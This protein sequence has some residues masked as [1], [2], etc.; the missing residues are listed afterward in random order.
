MVAVAEKLVCRYCHKE[1]KRASSLEVH[2]C[3]PKRRHN[4]QNEPGVRFG[5]QSYLR[6]YESTQGSA[7]KKTFTDFAGSPYYR[8]FT[9]FGRYCVDSRVLNPLRFTDYLLKQ[10]KKL[11]YWTS[12]ALYTEYLHDYLRVESVEDALT[13]AIEYGIA[14]EEET[15]HPAND[16]IR[17]GNANKILHAITTGRLSPW[18]FY[19][20]RSGQEFLSRL[21][22]SQV[23]HIWSYIDSEFWQKK[24]RDYP[25]DAEYAR[26]ILEKAG[27]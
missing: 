24:F 5:F 25:A 8:A 14:W 16:C 19:Q 20:S 11:D 21:D 15:T 23:A 12:D 10:N 27:W 17:Y 18:V 6:F 7:K 2:L 3:E 1:F 26:N 13:R 9:R 4:E 22:M